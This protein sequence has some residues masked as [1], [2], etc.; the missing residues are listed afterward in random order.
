V[1]S[2]SRCPRFK[3]NF[4]L[5]PMLTNIGLHL[6][7]DLNDKLP[8]LIFQVEGS[9]YDISR[10]MRSTR[11][12]AYIFMLVFSILA[13]KDCRFTLFGKHFQENGRWWDQSPLHWLGFSHKVLRV[14]LSFYSYGTTPCPTTQGPC[15]IN[16]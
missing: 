14:M 8:P 6:T 3:S 4:Y 10:E 11:L 12:Y 5:I 1:N 2:Q 16:N 9:P 15:Q 13:R 7:C